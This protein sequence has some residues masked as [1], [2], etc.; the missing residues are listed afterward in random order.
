M[1]AKRLVGYDTFVKFEAGCFETLAAAGMTAIKNGH[2]VFLS[3]GVDGV[4]EGEEILLGVNVLLTVC[5]QQDV[6]PFLEVQTAED[7]GCLD[8]FEVVVE[9]FCHW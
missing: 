6:F 8:V 9:N 2:V 5:R 1:E 4:E 3:H 7:V